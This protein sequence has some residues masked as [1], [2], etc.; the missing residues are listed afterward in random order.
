MRPSLLRE[1]VEQPGEEASFAFSC[2][3]VTS[4]PAP[5][6][7]IEQVPDG[8]A[9]HVEGV[10]GNRQ[11]KTRPE[12]QP[13]RLLHVLPP[14]PTEQTPPAGNLDGQPLS[15]K[16]QRGLGN[17]DTANVDRE[18]DEDRR[19][20][21][22]QDMADQDLAGRCTHGPSCQKIV[23]LLNADHGASGYS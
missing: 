7:G 19:H 9:E 17:D 13:G 6:P 22:G 3:A 1:G 2:G 18:D 8:V 10:D 12:R 11:G 23:I 14:F 5:Y 15:E 16:A 4:L 20:N 21:I